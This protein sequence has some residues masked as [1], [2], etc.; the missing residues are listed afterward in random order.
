MQSLL[1]ETKF[2][3]DK[4]NLRANKNLGQNFLIDENTV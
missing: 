3:L 2:I 1:N 4:Y